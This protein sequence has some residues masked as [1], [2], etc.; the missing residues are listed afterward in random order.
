MLSEYMK[1][2]IEYAKK[3][4]KQSKTLIKIIIHVVPFYL[5]L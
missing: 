4:T 3:F 1:K 5:P 2:N